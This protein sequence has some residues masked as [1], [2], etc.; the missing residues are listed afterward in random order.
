MAETIYLDHLSVEYI[1]TDIFAFIQVTRDP[2]PDYTDAYPDKLDQ[3]L[4]IPMKTFGGVDLYG[5]LWIKA[6]CY[7]YFFIKLHPFPNGNKRIA[8]VATL[9][10]LR[11]NG[12]TI[13][14]PEAALYEFSR[15]VAC[16]HAN[17]KDHLDQIAAFLLMHA[18]RL[19][20][21]GYISSSLRMLRDL[22][23]VRDPK[24]G[25]GVLS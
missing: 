8:I 17:Q 10:F 9:V 7:L 5:T 12:Y 13:E 22:I 3:V 15:Q 23:W 20:V 24:A 4:S 16:D 18:V 25:V 21:D 19:H 1:C 11:L 6:A 14:M 2:A